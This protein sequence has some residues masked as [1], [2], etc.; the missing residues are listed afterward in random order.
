[1]Y[2]FE[3][4]D[5][6]GSRTVRAKPNQFLA[7]SLGLFENLLLSPGANPTSKN[8]GGIRANEI[9][10]FLN[11]WCNQRRL[12]PENDVIEAGFH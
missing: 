8:S 6:L 1:M 11:I 2:E 10:G 12:K 9:K 7:I 3:R 5:P 4:I